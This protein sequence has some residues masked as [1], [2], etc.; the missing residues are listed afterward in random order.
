MS[1]EKPER[2]FRKLLKHFIEQKRLEKE[3]MS[4]KDY[5][6]YIEAAQNNGF[7]LEVD[8]ELLAEAAKAKVGR[9][10]ARRDQPHFVGDEY[11]G[12]CNVGGGHQIGWTK[13]GKR[14]HPS[15]FSAKVPR[16][17]KAA[18]AKVLGVEV[19]ILEAY[20][21]TEDDH[22]MLLFETTSITK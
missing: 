21:I 17:A 14:R 22:K 9:F 4:F 16:D 7:K 2:P 13:S 10:T 11:H 20:W 19:D 6:E 1:D 15:K 5:Y 3:R 18:V 12:Q 8:A